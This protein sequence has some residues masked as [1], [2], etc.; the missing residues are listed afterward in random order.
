ME[1]AILKGGEE[2]LEI[3]QTE[4]TGH[5]IVARRLITRGEFVVGYR[6]DLLETNVRGM[7]GICTIMDGVKGHIGVDGVELEEYASDD[8][9][10]CPSSGLH[11]VLPVASCS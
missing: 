11:V 8:S 6:G 1:S 5:G 3:V 4:T 9:N 10:I 7:A 2:E